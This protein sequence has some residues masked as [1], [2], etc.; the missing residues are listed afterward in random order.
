MASSVIRD[1]R[2]R[3]TR[4]A[5]S[6]AAFERTMLGGCPSCRTKLL[7]TAGVRAPVPQT[8]LATCRV[9]LSCARGPSP[10]GRCPFG[11]PLLLIHLVTQIS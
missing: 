7:K 4:G 3:I 6:K 1:T 2:G 9:L 5:L 11:L 8:H 10:R